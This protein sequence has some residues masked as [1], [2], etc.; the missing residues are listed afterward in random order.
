[1]THVTKDS[2]SLILLFYSLLDSVTNSKLRHAQQR[3][4]EGR[5]VNSFIPQGMYLYPADEIPN[6]KLIKK[7]TFFFGTSIKEG[8]K[9]T[10]ESLKI[11]IF[12][13][14]ERNLCMYWVRT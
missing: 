5:E 2:K 10:K 3:V 6:R 4:I 9:E 8:N 11:L 1:M 12:C 13:F 7:P 14:K